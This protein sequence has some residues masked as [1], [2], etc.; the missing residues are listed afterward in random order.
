MQQLM[1]KQSWAMGRCSQLGA[2]MPHLVP[3]GEIL[4]GVLGC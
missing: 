2:E 3:E 1:R 4:D